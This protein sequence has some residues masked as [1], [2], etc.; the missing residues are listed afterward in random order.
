MGKG[1]SG[2]RL[3]RGA[4]GTS[5]WEEMGVGKVSGETGEKGGVHK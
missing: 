3:G 5:E 1:A 2:E 4:S